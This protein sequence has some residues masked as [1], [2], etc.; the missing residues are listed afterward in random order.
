MCNLCD[1]DQVFNLSKTNWVEIDMPVQIES[2]LMDAFSML[3][4]QFPGSIFYMG[5]KGTTYCFASDTF[6]LDYNI[7]ALASALKK[8]FYLFNSSFIALPKA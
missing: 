8:D 5:A 6:V 1:L 3:K 7:L 2:A 4:A